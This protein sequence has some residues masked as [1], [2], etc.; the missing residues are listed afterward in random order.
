MCKG[1]LLSQNKEVGEA[2]G[3]H[4]PLALQI[5]CL[6]CALAPP[7]HPA[8]PGFGPELPQLLGHIVAHQGKM[9]G[10][11]ST[12]VYNLPSA[13]SALLGLVYFLLHLHGVLAQAFT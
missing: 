9:V 5:C 6:S 7:A 8:L 12:K 1:C 10:H 2:E 13:T 3:N 11:M 4:G